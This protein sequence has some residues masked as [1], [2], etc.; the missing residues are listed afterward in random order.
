MEIILTSNL[1]HYRMKNGVKYAIG[2]DNTNYL[3]DQIKSNLK[4]NNSILFI[5]SQ[6]TD[7]SKILEYAQIL[8]D[9]LKI[10]GIE[11]NNYY[12]LTSD[13]LDKIEEYINSSSLVFLSGGITYI[14]HQ[15]FQKINLKQLL[16]NY[17]GL[18]I[19]QSA[20]SIN[21]ASNVYNSPEDYD[22][23]HIYYEGLG[24]TDINIEPHFELDTSVFS[25]L[26]LY[27]REHVLRESYKRCIYGLPDGSHILINSDG[28][29][30]YGDIYEI[31][32]GKI[33]KYDSLKVFTK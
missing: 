9:A 26:D 25:E 14:Q 27:Q 12:V 2:I 22:E 11:F 23:S 17:E 18:V 21:L 28:I 19:G 8:F 1:K 5:P 20:G 29:S 7:D 4:N 33:N 24:L 15:L 3:V 16:S 6:V 32:D 30:F 13:K 10:S 31:R